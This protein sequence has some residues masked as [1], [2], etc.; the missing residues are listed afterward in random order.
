[1]GYIINQMRVATGMDTLAYSNLLNVCG[2]TGS[3]WPMAIPITMHNAT[4]IVR[5][6]SKNDIVVIPKST[7]KDRMAENFQI[8][9]FTLTTEDMN[10]VSTL[11]ENEST[12]S[13]HY[14]PKVVE[15]L[16]N[17]TK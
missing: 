4:H 2:T 13:S 15:H 3:H 10:A 8:F 1:M 9:D 5:Y 6:F 16:V 11:D 17:L 14:D 12:F 7:H